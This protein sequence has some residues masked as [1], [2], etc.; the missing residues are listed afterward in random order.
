MPLT[1]EQFERVTRFL[2][3]P[4]WRGEPAAHAGADRRES[5]RAAARGVAELRVAGCAMRPGELGRSRCVTV[6]VHDV[7]TGGVG[8]LSG[9]AVRA[10]ASVELVLSNGHDDLTLRCSVRHGSAVA[11]GR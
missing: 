6:Y 1:A 11:V 2:V 9:A 10:A 4:P 3:T 8:L 5:P 7:S